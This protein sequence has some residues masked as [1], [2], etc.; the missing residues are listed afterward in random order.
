MPKEICKKEV[1]DD[2]LPLAKATIQE[3]CTFAAATRA[4]FNQILIPTNRRYVFCKQ[5]GD[6]AELKITFPARVTNEI[7]SLKVQ[8]MFPCSELQLA[9]ELLGG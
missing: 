8:V 7:L 6:I 5:Y 9:Y 3:T 2:Y 1:L 4:R